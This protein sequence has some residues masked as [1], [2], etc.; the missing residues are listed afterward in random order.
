MTFLSMHRLVSNINFWISKNNLQK[1]EVGS[2]FFKALEKV[3]DEVADDVY[4]N[5]Y[6]EDLKK[7]VI[8]DIKKSVRKNNA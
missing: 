4:F 3:L 6:M 7:S 2:G 5:S 1:V 8:E